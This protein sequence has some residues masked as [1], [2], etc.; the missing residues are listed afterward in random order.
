MSDATPEDQEPTPVWRNPA[1]IAAIAT[2]IGSLATVAALVIRDSGEDSSSDPGSTTTTMARVDGYWTSD[3]STPIR[4]QQCV[5]VL[6]TCLGEPIDAVSEALGPPLDRY[7]NE[8]GTITTTWKL[9]PGNAIFT[10][11]DVGSVVYAAVLGSGNFRV[12]LPE[13][14]TLGEFSLRDLLSFEGEPYD[15]E[16]SWGE[17]IITVD[18]LQCTGPELN[19][20]EDYS[21]E[22]ADG[23]AE[24]Y[25]LNEENAI[26]RLGD[27]AVTGYSARS[28]SV[29][30][31]VTEGCIA[32]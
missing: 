21:L 26:D 27:R 8:D 31:A 2:L 15:V 10:T 11:D 14:R 22:V 3:G 6:G 13:G 9:G 23:D 20:A 7:D 1:W 18:V 30:N 12:A 4:S 5:G 32:R 28:Q 29:V 16:T 25:L 17:G 19:Y 24:A